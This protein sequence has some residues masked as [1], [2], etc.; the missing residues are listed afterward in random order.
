MIVFILLQL[1]TGGGAGG[2]Y[3]ENEAF[4][5]SLDFGKSIGP[6]LDIGTK[7]TMSWTGNAPSHFDVPFY[8]WGIPGEFPEEYFASYRER[9]EVTAQFVGRQYLGNFILI[10]SAGLSMQEYITLPLQDSIE[11]VPM[12]PVDEWDEYSFVFGTGVGIRIDKFDFC[13]TY[14]NRYGPLFYITRE[15][16]PR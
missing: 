10:G 16:G 13:L 4:T 5:V 15:F 11:S 3:G 9:N 14:C 1:F 6:Y 8:N 12:Y 2:F 7:L